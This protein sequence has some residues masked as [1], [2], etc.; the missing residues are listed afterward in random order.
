MHNWLCSI[1]EINSCHLFLVDHFCWTHVSFSSFK[2]TTVI[3]KLCIGSERSG[4]VTT[5]TEDRSHYHDQTETSTREAQLSLALWETSTTTVPIFLFG[6]TT[7]QKLP[8]TVIWCHS[9]NVSLSLLATERRPF[10]NE[11][12]SMNFLI[13][14]VMFRRCLIKTLWSIRWQPSSLIIASTF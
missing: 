6:H 11:K 3:W 4:F 12:V 10:F 2:W 1:S 13:T 8:E 14:K 5:T 7:E 9:R